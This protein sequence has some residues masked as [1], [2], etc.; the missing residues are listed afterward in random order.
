[1]PKTDYVAP[2][3]EKTYAVGIDPGGKLHAST[4]VHFHRHAKAR[5]KKAK[6]GS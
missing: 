2:H 6:G 5:T 1:M 3:K 4:P